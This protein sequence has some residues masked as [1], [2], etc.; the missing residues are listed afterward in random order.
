[1]IHVKTDGQMVGDNIKERETTG[2]RDNG[3]A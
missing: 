2:I 1:M 3:Q